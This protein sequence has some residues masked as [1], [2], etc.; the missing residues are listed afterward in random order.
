MKVLSLSP[1]W[2]SFPRKDPAPFNFKANTLN[3]LVHCNHLKG[4][5]DYRLLS[6]SCR[7]FVQEGGDRELEFQIS[8]KML[9]RVLV[10]GLYF[11]N[12]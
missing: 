8:Y 11:E 3:Y 5:L 7:G 2:D 1:V 6:L 12:L 10:P 9:L 4:L